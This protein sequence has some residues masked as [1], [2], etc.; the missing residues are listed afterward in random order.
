M[1]LDLTLL[2][3]EKAI[4]EAEEAFTGNLGFERISSGR[5]AEIIHD[6]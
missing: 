6:D 1:D 2:E 5:R 3:A 4:N